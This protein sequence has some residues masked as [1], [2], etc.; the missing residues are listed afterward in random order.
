[1]KLL[2]KLLTGI[3]AQGGDLAKHKLL[4]SH[5]A[6]TQFLEGK[7][8][9][10]EFLARLMADLSLSLLR[11]A[12]NRRRRYQAMDSGYYFE[13]RRLAVAVGLHKLGSQFGICRSK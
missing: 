1:M 13:S 7:I 12:G 8:S 11:R 2:S 9:E 3:K 10:E 6:V 5:L 4:L